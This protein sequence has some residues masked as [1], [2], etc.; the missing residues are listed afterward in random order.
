MKY[1]KLTQGKLALVDDEDFEYLNQ[2]RWRY[3]KIG[4]T[5]ARINGKYV[6]MHRLLMKTPK[7]LYTDHINM[8]KLD[9]RKSNL[10]NVTNSLNNFH[11]PLRKTN[12]SGYT[13]VVLDKR[14]NKWIAQII[15][16][17]KLKF[18]GY[19]NNITDA[20]YKRK[21]AELFYFREN[22]INL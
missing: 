17:R 21:E 9:N 18:L 3:L 14:R 6:Y 20:I 16:H 8:N 22:L 5:N 4:Y 1:I 15:F 13:G 12:A 10:R 7:G 11:K 19:F 2:W